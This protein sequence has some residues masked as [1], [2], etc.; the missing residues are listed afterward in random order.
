M[1]ATYDSFLNGGGHAES[2]YR[3]EVLEGIPASIINHAPE[4]DAQHLDRN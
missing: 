2:S 1:H 3:R 4:P